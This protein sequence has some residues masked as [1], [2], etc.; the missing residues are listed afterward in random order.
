MSLTI[1]RRSSQDTVSLQTSGQLT[2]EQLAAYLNATPYLDLDS[3][4]HAEPEGTALARGRFW[5]DPVRNAMHVTGCALEYL[6]DAQISGH[7][8]PSLFVGMLTAGEHVGQIGTRLVS[9]SQPGVPFV[10]G[11]GHSVEMRSIQ[12]RGQICQMHGFQLGLEFIETLA[13]EN[14]RAGSGL[15]ALPA[16]TVS[17]REIDGNIALKLLLAQLA[18]NPF[19]G[20][21]ARIYA[22][23]RILCALVELGAELSDSDGAGIP[24]LTRNRRDYAEHA[25]LLLDARLA[26]PPSVS[27][28]AREIGLNETDLRRSFK[29][30]FGLTIIAYL[31][32]RRLEIARRLVL[33]RKL[34][35]A[36]IAYRVGFASPANFATAYRRRFGRAPTRDL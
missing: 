7:Y 8:E 11:I 19:S 35:I 29:Q 5:C 25:R 32:D 3:R 2:V 17:M 10:I 31:R 26:N 22:E 21:L 18:D 23:S 14:G 12:R 33:E 24:R 27:E 4:H 36:E 13:Q 28:L 6:G 16:D 15:L 34:S 20:A 1:A 30:S 9:I